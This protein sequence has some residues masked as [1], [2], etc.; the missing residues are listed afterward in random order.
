MSALI[1]KASE[2][3]SEG[4]CVLK[5]TVSYQACN[6]VLCYPPTTKTI[7]IP[8]QVV[9]KDTKRNQVSGWKNW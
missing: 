5:A 9:P 2:E 6:D 4:E 8:I 7:E 1:F 3:L